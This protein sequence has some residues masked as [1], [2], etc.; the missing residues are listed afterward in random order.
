VKTIARWLTSLLSAEGSVSFGR[1]LSLVLVA[2]VLGWDSAQGVFAWQFNHH[3]PPG[4][5]PLPFTPTAAVIVAQTGFVTAFYVTTKA[6][7]APMGNKPATED[8]DHQDK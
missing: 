8:D 5:A 7:Y 3:L 6:F 2:F 4:F 1:V